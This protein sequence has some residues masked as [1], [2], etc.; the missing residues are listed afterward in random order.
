[1]LC[2]KGG[3]VSRAMSLQEAFRAAAEKLLP[4]KAK[5]T[6][7]G[8]VGGQFG[9]PNQGSTGHIRGGGD[10]TPPFGKKN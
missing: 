8:Q 10:R 6:M 4:D 1:M 9:W 2:G 7:D 3:T 5:S